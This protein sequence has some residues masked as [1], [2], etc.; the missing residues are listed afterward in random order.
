MNNNKSQGFTLLELL[1]AVT[2]FALVAAAAYASL[3]GIVR[4]R[5]SM[6]QQSE[7]LSR[8]Q[9]AIELIERDLA[10]MT[11]RPIRTALGD[12]SPGLLLENPSVEW[13]RGGLPLTPGRHGSTLERV[14]YALDGE[15]LIRVAWRQLD[16]A[17]STTPRSDE[18][19]DEI[20]SMRWRVMDQG[21]WVTRWPTVSSQRPDGWPQAVE[22]EL[23]TRQWGV[24][25]RVI[26]LPEAN[27][28]TVVASGELP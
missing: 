12:R 23:Q 21:R 18:L 28:D 7:S 1:I 22:L 17:P 13:V 24:V 8:L 10:A 26:A 6:Q 20:V 9:F 2:V 3:N 4:W 16:Q 27:W 14:R 25:R 19:L 5:A 15:R 11:R